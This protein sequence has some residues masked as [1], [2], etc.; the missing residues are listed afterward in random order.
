MKHSIAFILL[1][2]L[3]MLIRHYFHSFDLTGEHV[4][5]FIKF[6]V[7]TNSSFIFG[8][9]KDASHFIRIVVLAVSLGIISLISVY[10]YTFLSRELTLIRWGLT[11]MLAGIFG[12][13]LEKLF[14][15]HVIDYANIDLYPFQSYYFNFSDALQLIGLIIVISEVFKKQEII[16]FPNLRR[17]KILIYK[18]IQIS[19]AIKILGIVLIGNLTQLVLAFALLFPRMQ[20]GSDDLQI[21]FLMSFVILNLIMIPIIGYFLLKELLKCIGPIYAIERHL[22]NVDLDG[23]PIKLRKTDY[24]A[25][26]EISFN[27]FVDRNFK[28]NS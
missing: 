13:G 11:V 18:D 2:S 6:Q 15:N 4:L 5:G 25:S 21:L 28:E 3:T 24:F 23:Q 14:Y 8:L 26:L 1:L 10:F 19:I 17:Q 16:W 20:S 27:K 7:H 9:F 22:N 12:N